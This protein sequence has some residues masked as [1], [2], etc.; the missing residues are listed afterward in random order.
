LDLPLGGSHIILTIAQ[1]HEPRYRVGGNRYKIERVLKNPSKGIFGRA[2]QKSSFGSEF[3]PYAFGGQ[4]ALVISS[5]WT[6]MVAFGNLPAWTAC[7]PY[8]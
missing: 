7:P 8:R 3:L 2:S 1:V 4:N 6:T 5:R